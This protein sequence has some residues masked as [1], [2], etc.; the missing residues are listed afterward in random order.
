M[1]GISGFAIY[2]PPHRVRLEDWCEWNNQPWEKVGSVIGESFRVCGPEQDVY[3]LAATAALRLIEAYDIDPARIGQLALG[4][5]SASDNAAGAVIVR[6]MLDQRLRALGKPPL[7]RDCEVP[8]IKHACLGGVYALKQAS[9]YLATDGAGRCAI[10]VSAD[11]A[12][13]APGSSGEPTQGAG[14][15]AML[16]DDEARLL[17]IDL[18]A[19]GGASSYRGLDFRK[20]FARF[21]NQPVQ[22]ARLHDYPVF[23]G[24]YSTACY[25]DTV[26]NAVAGLCERRGG[27]WREALSAWDA[28]FM[29]RPY[30]RM[31]E[32]AL[33]L[34][35][36]H[37]LAADDDPGFDRLCV[38]M[39]LDAAAVRAELAAAPDLATLRAHGRLDTEVYP[40]A[41]ML[42]RHW[43]KSGDYAQRVKLSLGAGESVMRELGNLYTAALPAWLA[44]GL[45]SAADDRREL[46]GQ[47]WLAI[48]YG[49]GDAAEMLAL[50]M[51]P[52]WREA[53]SRLSLGAAL[54][55]ARKLDA[56]QYRSLHESG[57]SI[58]QSASLS[59]AFLIEAVGE[60]DDPEWADAGVARYRFAG[61][62]EG[63]A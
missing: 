20:P 1:L 42:L 29:H 15:V 36:L 5:E 62:H 56:R 24:R 51:A 25:F 59:D 63:Q 45:A 19:A 13:Y 40:Q 34:V 39:G 54:E 17:E 37:A 27:D 3:A 48:G 22:G 32:T 52:G 44:A 35:W 47:Q 53:A 46:A 21:S 8:E 10:V 57:G 18:T 16:L 60:R 38:E 2:V 33:G 6:G 61:Q 41:Q 14:A 30:A 11:I 26:R 43:R 49:S 4:T 28:I 23:N 12:E 58:P 9:R 55:G 50:T 7:A 31:P